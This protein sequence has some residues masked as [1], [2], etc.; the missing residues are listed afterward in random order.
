MFSRLVKETLD[1]MLLLSQDTTS[2]QQGAGNEAVL[3]TLSI[4]QEECQSIQNSMMSVL[5]KSWV[6]LAGVLD[7][8][9]G[10]LRLGKH[11]DTKVGRY[12]SFH[13]QL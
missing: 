13:S 5:E 12:Y 1:L 6:W 10:Q 4:G 2:T 11:F 9:E 3:P 8:V 7:V